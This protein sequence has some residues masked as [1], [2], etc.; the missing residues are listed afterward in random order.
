MGAASRSLLTAR[1]WISSMPLKVALKETWTVESWQARPLAY[2]RT[3]VKLV[4][5]RVEVHKPAVLEHRGY[6]G[7]RFDPDR[8]KVKFAA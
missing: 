5:E 4:T 2:R 1:K 6:L 7:A 3:I 8:V